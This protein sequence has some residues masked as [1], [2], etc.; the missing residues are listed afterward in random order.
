MIKFLL[1]SALTTTVLLLSVGCGS[2]AEKPMHANTENLTDLRNITRGNTQAIELTGIRFAAL[3]DT[4]LSLGA[5]GGLAWRAKIINARINQ[6]IRPME[7]IYNFNTMMLED[8]VLPPVL[9]EGRNTLEQTSSD[10]LRIAD[11][12][13]LIQSQAKFVT[14]APT[15]RD[16]LTLYYDKP[17][18]PDRSLLPKTEQERS[19]WDKFIQQGW[20]AGILQADAIFAENLGRLKRDYE[21]MIRYRS[22]LAQGIVSAPFVA[23]LD[24][25]ITGNANEMT[26]NDR[27]LRITVMPSFQADS[28]SWKTEMTPL[29]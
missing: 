26:V 3:R 20:Q 21:G 17:E 4:A 29:S 1:S 11:R 10:T 7:R 19:V 15:W 28:D 13:Y 23:K 24:L 9:L 12:A 6:Y 2:T 8:N 27:V 5:R 14:A 16:Y 22:L 25:G 18:V